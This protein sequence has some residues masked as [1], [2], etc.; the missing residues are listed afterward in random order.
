MFTLNF[1]SPELM[2]KRLHIFFAGLLL[3]IVNTVAGQSAEDLQQINT[4][5]KVIYVKAETL[6]QL[7]IRLR[8]LEAN[9]PAGQE[10]LMMDTYRTI[11]SGY[12]S[13]NHFK[14]AYQVYNRYIAFKENFYR[15][16]KANTLQAANNSI[17]QRK[18]ADESSV[19][20]L[21]N[22]VSQL[23]IEND[24]LIS[25]RSNFKKYFS[26]A[27]IALTA[28][29]ASLLVGSGIKL[30]NIRVKLKQ[31]R[32]RMK[33]IHRIATVGAFSKNIYPGTEN[34]LNQMDKD[35][36]DIRSA[37]KDLQPAG[38]SIGNIAKKVKEA[39]DQIRK[40]DKQS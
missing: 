8:P 1:I 29:F 16:E 30:N 15:K 23:Q 39:I 5:A 27:L 11:A 20:E 22:Q 37:V 6:D 36:E 25:R 21:Q 26:A 28:L 38:T 19:M 40:S 32:E 10:M 4:A 3:L 33:E 34:I 17:Q 2:N 24:Q 7:M 14:Q 9:L 18:S 13:N 31:S 12:A 35:V